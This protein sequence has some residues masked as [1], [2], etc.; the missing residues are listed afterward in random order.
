MVHPPGSSPS[1]CAAPSPSAAPACRGGASECRRPVRHRRGWSTGRGYWRGSNASAR[2]TS[3]IRA[4]PTN[5]PASKSCEP[6][7]RTRRT[8]RHD[9]G[10]G[11][12][13]A[14]A[15]RIAWTVWVDA[16][17]EG[18]FRPRQ[19]QPRLQFA[20]PTASHA[21][22]DQRAFIFRDGTPDLEQQL[23][24]GILAHR[25]VEKLDFAPVPLQFLQ[26]QDLMD[27]VARQPVRR[28]DHNHIKRSIR[29]AV[30]QTFKTPDVSG[31]RR[32]SRHHKNLIERHLPALLPNVTCQ[33]FHLLLDCLRLCLA[34]RRHASIEGHSHQ[35]P[36]A[37]RGRATRR[38]VRLPAPPSTPA[39][40]GRPD[41]SGVGCLDPPASSGAQ[42]TD[43]ASV[44]PCWRNSAEVVLARLD[45]SHSVSRDRLNHRRARRT[46][47]NLSFV[48]RPSRACCVD[49]HRRRT[50]F[51]G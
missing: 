11:L 21:L 20:R 39:P 34:L 32:C 45:R 2:L 28:S 27:I 7:P 30:A 48:I 47:Q 14:H 37:R 46:R 38:Q 40:P 23:V 5:E 13:E 12:L 36:P 49:Q 41:P 29:C 15:G 19:H 25:A 17:A 16:V 6:P 18:R 8:S 50:L 31:R 4:A 3:G 33:A 22:G 10:F 24:V 44:P 1:A 43:I 42:T 35:P 51:E 26:Q 9:G